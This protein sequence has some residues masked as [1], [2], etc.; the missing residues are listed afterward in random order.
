MEE[1]LQAATLDFVNDSSR[2]II[3]ENKVQLSNIFKWYKD[4]F[5]E[6][7][8]LT[9]YINRYSKIKTGKKAKVSYLTYD[10]GLNESR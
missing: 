9:D 4:D 8:S 10:W 3:S 2:N 1:Q 7:G 5:T 6:D